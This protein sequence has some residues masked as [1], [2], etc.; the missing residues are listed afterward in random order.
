MTALRPR[1]MEILMLK[2]QRGMAYKEIG[3]ELGIAKETVRNH[4]TN[5]YRALDVNGGE[6]ACYWLGQQISQWS[7]I[8]ALRPWDV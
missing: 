8:D 1:G 3:Q 7:E 4:L 6:A 2:C 5:V